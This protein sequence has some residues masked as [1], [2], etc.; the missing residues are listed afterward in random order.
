MHHTPMP[1]ASYI[2]LFCLL[3]IFELEIFDLGQLSLCIPSSVKLPTHTS[4][5][6]KTDC[7]PFTAASLGLSTVPG[8][9][10]AGVPEIAIK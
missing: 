7:T 4:L 8:T 10:R 2:Y 9:H 1:H 3:R 5:H 6:L